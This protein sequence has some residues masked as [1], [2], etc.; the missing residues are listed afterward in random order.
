MTY[1]EAMK[2]RQAAQLYRRVKQENEQLRNELD[3]IRHERDEIRRVY[4]QMNAEDAEVMAIV[5]AR[6]PNPQLTVVSTPSKMPFDFDTAEIEPV[7][8]EYEQI[9]EP[10][11]EKLMYLARFYLFVILECAVWVAHHFGWIDLVATLAISVF[12][13]LIANFFRL[14]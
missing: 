13:F 12:V 2:C 7:D 4:I 10:I 5:N 1:E 3:E 11:P 14:I 8:V 6:H 9:S